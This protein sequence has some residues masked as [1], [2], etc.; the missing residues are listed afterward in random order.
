MPLPPSTYYSGPVSPQQLNADL[1]GTPAISASGL[2]FHAHRPLLAEVLTEGGTAYAALTPQSIQSG[3]I[4]AFSIIDTTALFGVG[5]DYPSTFSLF[6]FV[7]SVPAS[8][9]AG[10][11]VGGWWLTW[12]FPDLETVTDPPGG[13]GAGMVENSSFLALG[14]FQYGNASGHNCPW[15]LDLISSGGGANTW[16]PGFYWLTPSAP[17]FVVSDDT[18]GET[19]RMGFLWQSVADA[20]AT[21]VSSVPSV[22]LSWGTVTSAALNSMGSALALLNTPPTLRVSTTSGQT[23][24]SNS[25]TSVQFTGAPGVDNYQGWSTASTHYVVQLPGLYLFSPTVVWGTASSGGIRWTSLQTIAGGTSILYQGPTYAATPVGPGVSGAGLTSTS[26]IRVL[27]LNAGDVV[28]AIGLQNSGI[29]VSLYTGYAS[30]LIGAWMGQQAPVGSV[31]T[32]SAPSTGFRFQAGALSGSELTAA[33]NDRLGN[34]VNFLL[35]RPY[36]TGYQAQEQTGFTLSTW[37]Q[38]NMDTLGAPPRGGNGDNYGGWSSANHWYSSQVA[39]WYLCIADLYAVPP[40]SGT[41]GVLTAGLFVSTSGGVTPANTP[42]LYQ[43]VPYPISTGGP[44]PGVTAMGVYYLLPGEYVYPAIYATGWGGTWGTYTSSSTV[45]TV[46]SQ[47]S[48]FYI[49]E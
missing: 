27:S 24:S 22:P 10:G 33:L 9:G 43:K 23:F 48:C 30:R 29:S 8:A 12:N 19:T 2:E 45:A 46:H 37:H 42:E 28:N 39:G 18:S 47:F 7:N 25:V 32:Y 35:N 14:V 44:P 5:G 41:A 21:P 31:L 11:Q 49:C 26:V 34:D 4:S 1:Y 20:Y 15:Y 17:Q 40:A 38:V 3:G 13:V 36:F 6:H 16:K